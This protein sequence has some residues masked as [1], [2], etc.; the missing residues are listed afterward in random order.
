MHPS[1]T[2]FLGS[3]NIF[4]KNDPPSGGRSA[5]CGVQPLQAGGRP[6]GSSLPVSSFVCLLYAFCLILF[7]LIHSLKDNKVA[8]F[9]ILVV[10][11]NRT[12]SS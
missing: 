8:V 2:E 12:D 6:C 1:G 9:G 10:D 11:V 5:A 4:L 3:V 7:I